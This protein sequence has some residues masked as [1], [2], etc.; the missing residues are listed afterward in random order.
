[1]GR[2]ESKKI[3]PS[4]FRVYCWLAGIRSNEMSDVSAPAYMLS[5]QKVVQGPSAI[6]GA[7]EGKFS[8]IRF[9]DDEG[10]FANQIRQERVAV[11]FVGLED[12]RRIGKVLIGND[13]DFGGN[14]L[15]VI[16]P[17]VEGD[18]VRPKREGL[19]FRIFFPSDFVAAI[20]HHQR[21]I[22]MFTGGFGVV[23]GVLAQQSRQVVP[24]RDPFVIS[25]EDAELKFHG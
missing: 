15:A 25:I 17:T 19:S 20:G 10:E 22:E 16:Q 2:W 5:V 14:V 6:H 12:E 13:A 18:G 9:P 24:V 7:A 23:A 1:M 11:F 3:T 8:G 21:A 4:I